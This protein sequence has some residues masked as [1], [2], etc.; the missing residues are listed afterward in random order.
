M[1]HLMPSTAAPKWPRGV[2]AACLV[3]SLTSCAAVAPSTA[4]NVVHKTE[5]EAVPKS[6]LLQ[7]PAP[8]LLGETNGDLAR[9]AQGLDS[10][11]ASCNA[12]KASILSWSLGVPPK[13][14]PDRPASTEAP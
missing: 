7:T 9:W 1:L 13:P 10:A 8:R 3:L 11:L 5:R 12:D 14:S 4:P 6:L 2:L